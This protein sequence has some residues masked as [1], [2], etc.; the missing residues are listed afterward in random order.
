MT[1]SKVF[2]APVVIRNEAEEPAK[3]PSGASQ[4]AASIVPGLQGSVATQTLLPA[5]AEERVGSILIDND[6][7]LR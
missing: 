3:R 2:A 4:P 1:G 6:S 5:D 7:H